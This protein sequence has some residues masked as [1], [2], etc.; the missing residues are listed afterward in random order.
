MLALADMLDRPMRVVSEDWSAE[1]L[2]QCKKCGL[3]DG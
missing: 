2:K 1:E 3:R